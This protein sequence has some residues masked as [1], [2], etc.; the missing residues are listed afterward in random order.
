MQF[1]S[2]WI[3][4]SEEAKLEQ[5]IRQKVALKLELNRLKKAENTEVQF[6][7]KIIDSL[8]KETSLLLSNAITRKYGLS[9][10]ML[11]NLHFKTKLG[12]LDYTWA[13]TTNGIKSVDDAVDLFAEKERKIDLYLGAE[14]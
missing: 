12:N 14:R 5:L 1:V 6:Y 2:A 3:G 7:K 10:A 9:L 4:P 13:Q 8:N 11:E